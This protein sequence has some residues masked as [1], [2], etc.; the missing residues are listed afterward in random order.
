LLVQLAETVANILTLV[1]YDLSLQTG[2]VRAA[3]LR[4]KRLPSFSAVGT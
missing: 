1:R 3:R 4:R 2:R